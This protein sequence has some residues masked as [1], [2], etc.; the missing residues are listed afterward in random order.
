LNLSGGVHY[1]M[2]CRLDPKE[3]HSIVLRRT[4]RQQP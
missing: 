3:G 1:V 2:D 4:R